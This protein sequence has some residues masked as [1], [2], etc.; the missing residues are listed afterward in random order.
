VGKILAALRRG[1]KACRRSVSLAVPFRLLCACGGFVEGARQARHQVR[2]CPQ[3]GQSLFVL[4]Y[5]RYAAGSATHSALDGPSVYPGAPAPPRF[6]WRG[7]VVAA[8]VT[9][10]VVVAGYAL[11]FF[12]WWK[13]EHMP[14]APG[15]P[16]SASGTAAEGFRLLGEGDFRAALAR[17]EEARDLANR[18]PDLV[19]RA[20]RRRIEQGRRQA[21]LLDPI[22]LSRQSLQ[23][24]LEEAK[25]ERNE[26]KWLEQFAETFQGKSVVFDDWV[27]RDGPESFSLVVYEVWA[28]KEKSRE[29]ARVELGDLR[30]VRDLG[31][32]LHESRRVLFGARL[33]SCRREPDA[34]WVF[35]F[36]PESGVLL[37]DDGAAAAC[38]LAPLDE[39]LRQVL[40][41]QERWLS[42]RP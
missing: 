1:W 4:P 2:R 21:E 11:L 30:L 24:I 6:S 3:C 5:V 25:G 37:T 18:R 17:F 33:A 35:R 29:R 42:E 19:P 10:T 34:G 15:D 39:P 38:G 12:V 23:E 41:D 13:P 31:F 36:E 32:G 27:R 20:E 28:G 7:P 26:A 14:T 40:R 8:L 22:R 16:P 9:L